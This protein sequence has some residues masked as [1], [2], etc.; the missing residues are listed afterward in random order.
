MFKKADGSKAEEV[1]YVDIEAWGKTGEL[2]MQYLKRGAPV[3]VE[4]RL[5][6]DTWEKEGKKH[7]KLLVV[8][9]RVHFLPT[10]AKGEG[11][12]TAAREPWE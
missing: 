7:S 8:A 6:Q 4:G 1:S 2:V 11:A 3:L 5:K 9:E 12:D 10:G